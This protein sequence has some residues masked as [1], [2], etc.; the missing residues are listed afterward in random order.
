MALEI[1]TDTAPLCIDERGVVRV[2]SSRVPLE[3][4]VRAFLEGLSAEEIADRF[5]ALSLADVYAALGYYLRW[6]EEVD[7]YIRERERQVGEAWQELERR[8]PQHGLRERLLARLN[9]P[10]ADA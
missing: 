5:D 10:A 6:R 9:P 4:V 8:Y 1:H 3:V 2:G 7:A